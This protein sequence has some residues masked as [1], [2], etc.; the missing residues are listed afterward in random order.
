MHCNNNNNF[1][2]ISQLLIN[3]AIISIH[4]E[5]ATIHVSWQPVVGDNK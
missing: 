4:L 2:I 1:I 5:I 3:K